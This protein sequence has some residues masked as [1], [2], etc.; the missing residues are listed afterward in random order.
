MIARAGAGPDPIPYKQLT[1]ENLADAINF[2]LKP[3]SLDRAKDLASKITTEQGSDMGAQSFHQYLEA[4]RLRCTLAPSRAAVWRIRRTQVKLSA[5]AA[6]TLANA[7]LLDF[8]D[9]KLFRPQ[10][11]CTDEG[12]W[13]PLS[14]F[15]MA[16]FRTL[17]SMTMG[18]ADFPSETVKAVQAPFGPSRQ[19]SQL[20]VQTVAKRSEPSLAGESSPSSAL[21][22]QHQTSQTAR[23]PLARSQTL[24]NLSSSLSRTSS[25]GSSSTAATPHGQFGPVQHD[26]N[27]SQ[28]RGQKDVGL[29]NDHDMLRPTGLRT[30]KG[31]GRIVK[32]GIQSPMELSVG[33]TKGFHNAPKLWGDDTVRPQ[34][35][36]SDLKS[37]MKAIGREFGYGWYDGVT[38][39]FTQPWRGAQREGA[40]GFFK[41][42]GKGIGGFLTKPG[43][44]LFGIPSHMMKGVHKEVQKLFGSNLQTYIVTSR[45]AQGYQEWLQS[46]DAEKEDVTDRWTRI[47]KYLKKK[48][49]ADEMMRDV[50]E[51]QQKRTSDDR[52]ARRDNAA[53][54]SSPQPADTSTQGTG[55]ATLSSQSSLHLG[56]TGP[57]ASLGAPEINDPVRAF[58]QDMSRGDA[59]ADSSAE[60]TDQESLSQL[61]RQRQEDT[62]HQSDQELL[63]AIASSEAEAQRHTREALE[64]EEQLKQVMAQSLTEQRRMNGDSDEEFATKPDEGRRLESERAGGTSEQKAAAV[65]GRALGFQPPPS[66]DAHHLAGTTQE[67]FQAQRPEEKTTQE[68]TEEQ[69]VLEY[70]KKQSLL[71][72]HHQGKGKGRARAVED[73]D[74]EDL[75][76]ALSM[77]MQG[78]E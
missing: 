47:Q 24:P 15:S 14:G 69:I 73:D 4:D 29:G 72:T 21:T 78:R 39:L 56:Y 12:P 53:T 9:L 5:F 51:A 68:K 20:S 62:D 7:N 26:A 77:S 59:E 22:E 71:E 40:S 1:A 52:E 44:A 65:T 28:S 37:G 67:E 11:Y 17:G 34:E 54:A 63:Q 25:V 48:H 57:E 66:Y 41:G 8:H 43:A 38:G 33:I 42:I 19:Q 61:R 55:S 23:K 46:S 70:I 31:F 27:R 30:S 6:C 76:K 35:K 13:D 49:D 64:Y 60:H 45:T 3:E 58:A 74:D 10:E 16:I 75:Q 18:I 50:L 36:V 32:A 2:C